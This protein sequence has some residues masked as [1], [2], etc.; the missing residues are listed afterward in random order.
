MEWGSRT[1]IYYDQVQK[2]DRPVA[3]KVDIH[4]GRSFVH[5]HYSWRRIRSSSSSSS[6]L[7]ACLP[8]LHIGWVGLQ[9]NDLFIKI[10]PKN[11][12]SCFGRTLSCFCFDQ[13]G[14]EEHVLES[15]HLTSCLGS[16]PNW[17]L[18][19]MLKSLIALFMTFCL[20]WACLVFVSGFL[21][22]KLGVFC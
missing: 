15:L 18:R 20:F 6:S 7:P 21:W 4:A 16:L 12:I 14:K 10:L 2:K 11:A 8:A 3:V 17:R 19:L 5:L 9:R 22:V 13:L 1:S